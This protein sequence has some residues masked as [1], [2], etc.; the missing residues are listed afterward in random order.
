MKA[1]SMLVM[2][3]QSEKKET[4]VPSENTKYAKC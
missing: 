3:L 1:L 2:L 4:T